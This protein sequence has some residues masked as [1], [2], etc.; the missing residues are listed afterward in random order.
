MAHSMPAGAQSCER[1]GRMA[2]FVVVLREEFLHASGNRVTCARWP[3]GCTDTC[4]TMLRSLSAITIFLA[5]AGCDSLP[6]DPERTLDRVRG[7]KRMRVGLVENPP[8]VVH[9]GS[10]PAGAEVELVKRF[11]DSLGAK[12]DWFWGGEQSHMEALNRFELD[13]VVGGLTQETPWAKSIG[14]TKPYFLEQ[15]GVGVLAGSAPP[16]KLKDV[17]VA[18]RDGDA[19]AHAL[20]SKG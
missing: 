2:S 13:L 1:R 12:P 10:K 18:V 17:T 3:Y 19:A 14:M 15:I 8:W 11:A 4:A 9:R 6:R 16:Q 7:W 20:I 5:L